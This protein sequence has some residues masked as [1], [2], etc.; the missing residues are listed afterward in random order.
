MRHELLAVADP[1]DWL[2]IL[3]DRGI[4]GGA[5]PVEDA[6]RSAGDDDALGECEVGRG[7]FA[8]ANLRVYAQI[9]DFTGLQM[10]ILAAGVQNDDLRC[11]VQTSVY[12]GPERPLLHEPANATPRGAQLI[13]ERIVQSQDHPRFRRQ[14]TLHFRAQP[15]LLPLLL[16]LV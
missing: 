16:R 10:T 9:P 1:E 8:G 3:E 4:D 12:A 11:G 13:V 2:A 5:I 7:R 15:L 14:A 6:S